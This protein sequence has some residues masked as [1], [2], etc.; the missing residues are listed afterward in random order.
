MAVLPRKA[1]FHAYD[2]R[3]ACDEP[4]GGESFDPE[5]TTEGLRA[6]RLSRI[7]ATSTCFKSV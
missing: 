2:S 6:E 4:F 1:G 7:E 5:L 3:M